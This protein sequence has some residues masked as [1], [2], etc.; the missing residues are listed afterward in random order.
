MFT[1]KPVNLEDI[2]LTMAITVRAESDIRNAQI[3]EAVKISFAAI[4]SEVK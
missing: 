1:E 3:V 4:P 2:K